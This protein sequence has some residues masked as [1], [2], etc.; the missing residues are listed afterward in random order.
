MQGSLHCKMKEIQ[1]FSLVPAPEI[2]LLP[3]SLTLRDYSISTAPDMVC[4]YFSK[5]CCA[6]IEPAIYS[7][8]RCF[9]PTSA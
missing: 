6:L 3:I 8:L 9:T 7:Y 1:R 5:L 4:C 2:G